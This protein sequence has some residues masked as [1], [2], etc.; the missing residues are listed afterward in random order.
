MAV[1]LAATNMTREERVQL[2]SL[3]TNAPNFREFMQSY[4]DWRKTKRKSFGYA[5]LAR[6]AGFSARSYPRDVILGARPPT[7]GSISRFT[8][9][10]KLTGESA[11]Y[12]RLL[13]YRD[14]PE[15]MQ[16]STEVDLARLLE[17][18][19]VR[20]LRQINNRSQAEL[21]NVYSQNKWPLIYAS[22]GSDSEGATP[23]EVS[24]RAHIP[25]DECERI[26]AVLENQKIV[27]KNQ[28]LRRYFSHNP[29]LIFQDLGQNLAFKEFF[30][31]SLVRA[32]KDAQLNF[33][34]N[35]RL[36]FSSVITIKKNEL[37]KYRAKLR[38]LLDSFA[39]TT[40]SPNGD[41]VVSIVCSL[42]P[43]R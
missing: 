21:L 5:S 6:E 26:L 40:E 10:M 30:L 20:L 43:S 39:E 24:R 18:S 38:D 36:F 14:R 9:A 7:E 27:K 12:F 15:L 4:V 32:K 8:R 25:I 41:E 23:E 33:N 22:L 2:W 34:K 37:Q 13:V 31:N 35:D 19:R 17:K 29:H 3:L 11:R 42:F 1:S 16:G 28:D